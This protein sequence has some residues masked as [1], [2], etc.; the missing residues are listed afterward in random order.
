MMITI[1][2]NEDG[3]YNVHTED[4]K[5]ITL[6]DQQF[7]ELLKEVLSEEYPDLVK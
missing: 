7:D 2:D 4:K 5:I 1:H 3:T 6:T